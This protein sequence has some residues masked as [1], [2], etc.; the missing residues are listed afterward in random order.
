MEIIL[1]TAGTGGPSLCLSR[2]WWYGVRDD[3]TLLIKARTL[4]IAREG[5]VREQRTKM[6]EIDN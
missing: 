3:L 5:E 1:Q 4:F 6:Y 2:W